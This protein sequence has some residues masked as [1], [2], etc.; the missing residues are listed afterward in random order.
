VWREAMTLWCAQQLEIRKQQRRGGGQQRRPLQ[1]NPDMLGERCPSSLRADLRPLHARAVDALYDERAAARTKKTPS[2][3][4][5]RVLGSKAWT[6]LEVVSWYQQTAGAKPK[7]R[8]I[9]LARK[10]D[11]P[12]EKE[13]RQTAPLAAAMR[14]WRTKES[15]V[16]RKR[17]PPAG[18]GEGRS[19]K[20]SR[21]PLGTSWLRRQLQA[22][23]RA[24]AGDRTAITWLQQP[25]DQPPTWQ[26]RRTT[27]PQIASR[28]RRASAR[29][30]TQLQ[31]RPTKRTRATTTSARQPNSQVEPHIPD[32]DISGHP[33]QTAHITP[34]PP[35][36][37][38]ITAPIRAAK[39][40]TAACPHA[41]N[42]RALHQ[43]LITQ[44]LPRAR[45]SAAQPAQQHDDTAALAAQPE[46]RPSGQGGDDSGGLEERGRGGASTSGTG[47]SSSRNLRD[48]DNHGQQIRRPSRTG[49]RDGE[50]TITRERDQEAK[51]R[52]GGI[53]IRPTY[54][55][56]A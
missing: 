23:Y 9:P 54:R 24:P 44:L 21:A 53:N 50:R 25:A 5:R 3:A 15:A 2:S 13:L 8:L 18:G 26:R 40:A 22:A 51:E 43:P 48:R 32:A 56:N 45:T 41:V 14:A 16:D 33:P 46:Q 19:A 31:Q 7:A 39:T 12:G 35:R 37:R 49:G 28:K 27:P 55:R 52:G 1:L 4:D 30:E 42:R 20:R 11:R 10:R 34:A 17:G 6:A 29:S 38:H 47:S 36:A